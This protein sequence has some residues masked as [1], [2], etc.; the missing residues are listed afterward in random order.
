MQKESLYGMF[1]AL[2]ADNKDKKMF[3]RVL[4]YIP[5][6]MPEVDRT[7]GIWARPAN[8]P[9]GG[10]NQE[11]DSENHYAGTSYI[12][13]KGSW[14][15]V[16]FEGGNP[17]RPYYFGALD[18]ESAKTLPEN[19][20]GSNPSDKWVI[21][22]TGDGRAI[23]A[24]DDSDDARIEITGK[25]RQ[26]SSPPSGDTD[27]VYTIDNN[28]TTILFD[29]R[30][31][32][33]KILIRTHKGDF[34]HIDVDEQ[35]LQVSFE[36]DIIIKAGNNIAITAEGD[37]NIKANSGDFNMQAAGDMNLKS[38]GD[39]NEEAGGTLNSK[40]GMGHYTEAGAAVSHKGGAS[41][42]NDAP[43]INDNSGSSTSAGTATDATEADP[44]GERDT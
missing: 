32:K 14:V 2:V 5:D 23:V 39:L 6:L 11:D 18:L 8:N 34:F 21:I 38:G 4:V 28:M 24:S 42:D 3:G 15:F 20:V 37:I 27:S 31:G 30:S 19:Q 1:R 16:F 29:E 7:K 36:N 44:E 10:R 17:N 40:A 12:P 43:I 33:E 35:N 13:A 26:I 22:K 25:K 9:I 41:I